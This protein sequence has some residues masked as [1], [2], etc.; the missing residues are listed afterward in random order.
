[1]S[2]AWHGSDARVS[3]G[4]YMNSSDISVSKGAVRRMIQG[5]VPEVEDIKPSFLALL[6]RIGEAIPQNK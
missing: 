2:A 3:H 6:F 4:I 1:M 5:A